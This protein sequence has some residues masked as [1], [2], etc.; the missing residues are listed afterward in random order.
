MAPSVTKVVLLY[1]NASD[2]KK[3][4]HRLL[5]IPPACPEGQGEGA[6]GDRRDHGQVALETGAL[7]C[8]VSGFCLSRS[9][10]VGSVERSAR[11][12]FIG[13]FRG[14]ATLGGDT[15]GEGDGD[16]LRWRLLLLEL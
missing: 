16:G 8:M 3:H 5:L 13:H 2:L 14:A 12:V 1:A 15:Q 9:S 11:W 10:P 7:T 6:P 4:T